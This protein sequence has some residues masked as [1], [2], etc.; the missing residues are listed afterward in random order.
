M[1]EW[2]K[3]K[4]CIHTHRKRNSIFYTLLFSVYNLICL[5]FLES[6]KRSNDV[7]LNTNCVR[8]RRLKLQKYLRPK[9]GRFIK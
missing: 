3:E 1:N 5:N 7:T 4:N 2:T 6:R 9:N 8:W